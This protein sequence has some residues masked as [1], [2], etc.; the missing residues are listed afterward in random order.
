MD[1]MTIREARV[2]ECE[3]L[4]ELWKLVGSGPSVTDTVEHLQAL[5]RRNGDLLL[6]AEIRDQI[7]G[8]VLG[9]WD[10]WRGHIYRL[11]VHPD[12]RNRGI[13]RALVQEI[14]R[15]LRNKGARLIYALTY[16]EDGLAFWR[17]SDYERTTDTLFVRTYP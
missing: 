11:A 15:R 2:E 17:A 5:T 14:E 13:A 6:V 3:R 8:T 9:G 12:Q 16:T 7:V 4:L 10:F 1:G